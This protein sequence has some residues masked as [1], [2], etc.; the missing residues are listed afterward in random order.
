[1]ESEDF[2]LDLAEEVVFNDFTDNNKV[3]AIAG[4]VGAL[5]AIGALGIASGPIT[6]PLVL[7]AGGV[8]AG[9]SGE[10]SIKNAIVT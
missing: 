4:G 8:L 9:A 7:L 1:M 5:Y 2:V 3:G 10:S 6:I